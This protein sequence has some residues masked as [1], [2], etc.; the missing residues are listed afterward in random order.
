MIDQC[1]QCAQPFVEMGALAFVELLYQARSGFP[2]D[3]TDGGMHRMPD[4]G[5]AQH[6]LAPIIRRRR[7]LYP[8][9]LHQDI[10]RARHR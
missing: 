3:I 7:A 2:G 6:H 4:R 5:K 8:L 9:A 1:V 10:H